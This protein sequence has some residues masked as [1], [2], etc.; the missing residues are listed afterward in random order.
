MIIVSTGDLFCAECGSKTVLGLLEIRDAKSFA[1]PHC[2][3]ENQI[4]NGKYSHDIAMY[5]WAMRQFG[6][7]PD[8]VE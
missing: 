1:C 6:G 7:G 3:R 2:N 5:E 4:D 8:A